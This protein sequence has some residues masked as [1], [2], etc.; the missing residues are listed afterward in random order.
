[1]MMGRQRSRLL[2]RAGRRRRRREEER[3][4]PA[5]GSLP[6]RSPAVEEKLDPLTNGCRF[7]LFG[8][9]MKN[10]PEEKYFHIMQIK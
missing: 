1:M 8:T 7:H 4:R 2:G 3:S 9:C 5:S 10:T 6:G